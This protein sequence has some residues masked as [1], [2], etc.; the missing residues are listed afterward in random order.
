MNILTSEVLVVVAIG[1][2]TGF[3][4]WKLHRAD[5]RREA[6]FQL[7]LRDSER[8]E[9]LF[10]SVHRGSEATI[11]WLVALVLSLMSKI[12]ELEDDVQEWTDFAHLMES[13]AVFNA[14]YK[15]D[16]QASREYA[17]EMKTYFLREHD[18][19]LAALD[20]ATS[21]REK[22]KLIEKF[23]MLAIAAFGGGHAA[24]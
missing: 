2:P 14:G 8:R 12:T 3:T 20:K 1:T 4:L 21:D 16:L 15:G 10:Q 23:L 24:G 19:L 11:Q 18:K 6:R 17:D 7:M 13:R 9:V 22:R 5:E